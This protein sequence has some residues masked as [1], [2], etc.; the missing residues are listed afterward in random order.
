VDGY[1]CDSGCGAVAT[2]EPPFGMD[3]SWSL[4]LNV[5]P[6][7][8]I[9]GTITLSNDETLQLV[10][11]AKYQSKIDATSISAKGDPASPAGKGTKIKMTIDGSDLS[12]DSLSGKALGQKV[13]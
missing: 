5:S 8:L 1:G 10:G 3:G 4:T 12:V 7:Q 6:D 2:V 11:K 9:T 13:Q